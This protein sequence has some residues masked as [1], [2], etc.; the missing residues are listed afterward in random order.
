M[1]QDLNKKLPTGYKFADNNDR[2]RVDIT[3]QDNDTTWLLRHYNIDSTN[4]KS[5]LHFAV[6][7]MLAKR[8]GWVVEKSGN[9]FEVG[10]NLLMELPCGKT[11]VK[12]DHA[13][14]HN[15]E[16]TFTKPIH[17]EEG[18]LYL[19]STFSWRFVNLNE[20]FEKATTH[21]FEAAKTQT[22]LFKPWMTNTSF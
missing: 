1:D 3:A 16:F 20:A 12:S 6:N 15:A 22:N 2:W 17:V 10:P 19:C 18:L 14:S 21:V 8:M 4:R 5:V 7:L 11:S 13:T 9:V